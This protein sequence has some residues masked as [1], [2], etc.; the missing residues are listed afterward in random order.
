MSKSLTSW[1]PHP[2]RRGDPGEGQNRAGSQKKK[3][4]I[5]DSGPGSRSKGSVH[6]ISKHEQA[7]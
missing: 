2:R 1:T 7:G 6:L 3:K 4:R 5:H